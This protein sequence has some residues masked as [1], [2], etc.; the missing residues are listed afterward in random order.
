MRLLPNIFVTSVIIAFYACEPTI[1]EKENDSNDIQTSMKYGDTIIELVHK[2]KYSELTE[3]VDTNIIKKEDLKNLISQMNSSFGDM[4]TYEHKT[5]HT[6]S[7]YSN[8][9]LISLNVS[10]KSRLKF[11]KE[12]FICSLSFD[13]KKNKLLLVGIHFD[14]MLKN[15]N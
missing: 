8:N 14:K 9:K 2:K 3:Y 1:V 5:C 13:Y 11:T 12:S 4:E 10:L 15:S 7:K 6:K